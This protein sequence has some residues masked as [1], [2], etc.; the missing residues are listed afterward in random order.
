MVNNYYSNTHTHIYIIFLK[1]KLC[2]KKVINMYKKKA[3]NLLRYIS[4]I[5][6]FKNY[7]PYNIFTEDNV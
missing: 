2:T 7:H 6:Y 1:K 5:F 3:N 4:V